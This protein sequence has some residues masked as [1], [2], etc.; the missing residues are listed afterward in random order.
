MTKKNKPST[1]RKVGS[2]TYIIHRKFIG[3]QSL[4]SIIER[5]ILQGK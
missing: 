2:T 5:L 4:R 1:V 3:D